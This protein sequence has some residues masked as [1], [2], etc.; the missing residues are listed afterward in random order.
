MQFGLV[1]LPGQRLQVEPDRLLCVSPALVEIAQESGRLPL[2]RVQGE[3]A[4]QLAFGFESPSLTQ[5]RLSQASMR[6]RKQ[7]LPLR[8]LPEDARRAGGVP[9]L[10][11]QVPEVDPE[12][13]PAGRQLDFGVLPR[14][15]REAAVL[16][17][18]QARA[19]LGDFDTRVTHFA[20]LSYPA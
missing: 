6:L 17:E 18:P 4:L 16:V 14:L 7:G 1:R 10:E 20:T 8:R 3:G 2:G 9:P 11:E 13:D 19:A 12:R 5:Q 15:G